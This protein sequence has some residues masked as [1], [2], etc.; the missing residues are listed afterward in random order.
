VLGDE[1]GA[2]SSGASSCT[3]VPPSPSDVTWPLHEG[4]V[5][6]FYVSIRVPFDL[7][8]SDSDEDDWV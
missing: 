6:E 8:D 5:E 4:P 7:E 2:S 1:S 3:Y